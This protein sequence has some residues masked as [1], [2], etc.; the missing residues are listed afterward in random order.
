ML[1]IFISGAP[2]YSVM[3]YQ[4]LVVLATAFTHANIRL[5][6]WLDHSLSYFLISPNMHKV[7]HH[8]KQPYTDSNYGAVFSIWDR[9]LGTFSKLDINQ[10]KYGLDKHYPAEK[11]EDVMSLLKKPF[12]PL[13]Y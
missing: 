7:H 5:P 8:W 11:D 4:T 1:L 13:D 12:Q 6:G 10:V 3:M 9:L 2:M